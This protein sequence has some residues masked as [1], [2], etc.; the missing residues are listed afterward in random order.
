MPQ[1]KPDQYG[2]FS[3]PV[4]N[5]I[6]DPYVESSKVLRST[7]GMLNGKGQLKTAPLKKGQTSNTM[8]DGRFTFIPS[9][10]VGCE[11]EDES[12]KYSRWRMENKQKMLHGVFRYSHPMKMSASPGDMAGTFPM[13]KR[14][15]KR[16]YFD[17]LE[18]VEEKPQDAPRN[19][20]P[21]KPKIKKENFEKPNIKIKPPSKGG[22]GVVG[23][24]IGDEEIEYIH[25]PYVVDRLKQIAAREREDHQKKQ[26]LGGKRD[27]D[28]FITS[29][30]SKECF[31]SQEHCA[32]SLVYTDD[33]APSSPEPYILPPKGGSGL[34]LFRTGGR[35]SY[36]TNHNGVFQKFPEHVQDPLDVHIIRKALLPYRAFPKKE[37]DIHLPLTLKDRGEFL[38]S[39]GKRAGATKPILFTN[40]SLSRGIVGDN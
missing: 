33:N 24:R 12:Q 10:G 8:G 19:R 37:A 30:A 29:S 35:H 31:D 21:P 27:G 22:P 2:N 16:R 20:P 18:S 26:T 34:P 11:Y 7:H 25:E 15:P 36:I 4:Y 14:Q 6:G 38:P 9:P 5:S 3:A 28:F 1:L 39:S 32:A 13:P 17:D 40:L 23:R